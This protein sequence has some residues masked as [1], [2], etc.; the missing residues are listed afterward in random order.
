MNTPSVSPV[1]KGDIPDL[2]RIAFSCSLGYWSE[3]DLEYAVEDAESIVLGLYDP[4]GQI[5][6]FISGRISGKRDQP[7]EIYNIGILPELR[8]R[9]SGSLLLDAFIR[10]SIDAGASD[11]WLEVRDSNHAATQFYISKGFTVSG[12]RRNFY[13]EPREDAIL[14]TLRLSDAGSQVLDNN[15]GKS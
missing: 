9:G 13:S 4:N 12:R 6:G 7:A 10:K 15:S 11:V 3:H 8:R 14:M 5:I 2:M 1:G